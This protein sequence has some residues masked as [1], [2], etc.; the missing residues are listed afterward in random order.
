MNIEQFRNYCL[1]LK[2]TTEHFPFD[3]VTL[4]FKVGTPERTKMYAL[5][6]LDRPEFKVN[7]KGNP[8]R[9]KELREIYEE[10]QPGYHMNK[11]HWN[12]VNFEGNIPEALLREMINE[13]YDLVV[14]SFP[15]KVQEQINLSD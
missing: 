11:S 2:G 7:L 6:G 3:D 1:S 14:K 4:V 12:T 5:T 9:N 8:E 13:S 10:I 15:K